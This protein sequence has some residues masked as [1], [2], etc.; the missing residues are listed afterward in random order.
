MEENKIINN[1]ENGLTPRPPIVVVMG[2]I[3]HGKSS[4]L[5][6]IRKTSVV[7]K[8]AG[9]ITQHIGAY[10]AEV[11][12]GETHG[13]KTVK[14]TFLDTPGHE[15][16]SQ[17]RARGAKI[18]DI[19]VLVIAADDGIKPQTMEAY[20]AIVGA[21]LPFVVAVNK[22]DKPNADPEK[23]KNQLAEKGILVEGYGG[24]I[25]FVKVSAKSGE[26]VSELLDMIL[27]LAEMENLSANRNQEATGVVIESHLDQQR[28]VS[29][30]LLILDG[31]MRK[32]TFIACGSAIAPVRIFEDFRGKAISEATV[33]SPVSIAGF[34]SMPAVGSSFFVFTSKSLAEEFAA[35][36]ALKEAAAKT[37]KAKIA[38][39]EGIIVIN[40]LLKADVSGSLEALE[41]E[42]LKLE[43]E[44]VFLEF[45]RVGV[46]KIS[47]NDVKHISGASEPVV[48]G[49]NIDAETA[50]TNLA[51][52]FSIPVFTSKIIYEI[53]DWLKIEIER[54]KKGIIREE[55][56]GQAK[57]L[58][59]FSKTKTKQVIGGK[60]LV[61]KMVGS[62]PVRVRRDEIIIGSGK[63]TNLQRN[64]VE[65]GSVD[66]GNEFGM[67]VELSA[68]IQAG[69]IV[70]IARKLS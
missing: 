64:K 52:R 16:F 36:E 5:D 7:N 70:E 50:A 24:T 65:T 27:L 4:L 18:A 61:G 69:D 56:I 26:G 37:K 63:I 44:N 39:G 32:G 22:I 2:H 67:M 60:V 14:I 57:V 47:E 53:S 59:T 35:K 40:V 11:N 9:G 3:D 42:L 33:S 21:D 15:A 10:E 45:L 46:G 54:R 43:S 17:M 19:A 55:I 68:D 58:K 51:E 34:N 30:S 62:G 41:K 23:V 20:N 66:E 25:P 12:C 48:F 49:F 6:Y 13:H 29:A 8:E 1:K 38:T 31:T 28:G